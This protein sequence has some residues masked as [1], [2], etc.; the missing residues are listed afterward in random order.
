[1]AGHIANWVL[2]CS[3]PVTC[4]H[5][6]S[7]DERRCKQTARSCTNCSLQTGN[8]RAPCSGVC[9]LCTGAV[10]TAILIYDI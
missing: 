10:A 4:T 6:I 5:A 3:L 1:M 2:F 7:A 8:K 9:L